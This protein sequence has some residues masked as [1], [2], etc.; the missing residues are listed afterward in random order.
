MFSLLI[1]GALALFVV[2]TVLL[3]LWTLKKQN[4]LD[5]KAFQVWFQKNYMGMDP[6][7]KFLPESGRKIEP[8]LAPH[9][10]FQPK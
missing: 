6:R 4:E 10:H 1:C 5:V 3:R 8:E 7:T 9:A 2:I